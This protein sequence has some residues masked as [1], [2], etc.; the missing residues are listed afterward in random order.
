[1][2]IHIPD[3]FAPSGNTSTGTAGGT[4]FGPFNLGVDPSQQFFTMP[5]GHRINLNNFTSANLAP[6]ATSAS[7]AANEIAYFLKGI[8][9]GNQYIGQVDGL[10]QGN[11]RA[12]LAEALQNQSAASLDAN[13][14]Q[15]SFSQQLRNIT[16]PSS[17]K[18]GSGSGLGGK[19]ISISTDP[20]VLAQEQMN[21]AALAAEVNS[22]NIQANGQVE[23]ANIGAAASE[24]AT[25]AS[26]SYN[27][28]STFLNTMQN[29]G[30]GDL[31]GAAGVA[32]NDLSNEIYNMTV[33][34]H[35]VM[36]PAELTN[37]VMDYKAPN[38]VNVFD[39]AFPGLR[40][41]NLM[42]GDQRT[43][44]EYLAW[45]NTLQNLASAYNLPA[46]FTSPQYMKQLWEGNVSATELEDRVVK[47]Y[48]AY[49]NEDEATKQ[50]LAKEY[51]IT[52]AEGAAYFLNPQL[53]PQE[54][55]MKAKP[56]AG[57]SLE[58]LRTAMTSAPIQAYANTTGLNLNKQGAEQLGSMVSSGALGTSGANA[59]GQPYDFS[60]VRSAIANASHDQPLTHQANGIPVHGATVDTNQLVGAQI[61]GY[62]GGKDETGGPTM[63]QNQQA[64]QRAE[65]SRLAPFQAGGGYAEDNKGAVGVGND[66]S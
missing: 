23:A 45:K 33:T 1:M 27:A 14:P 38:G 26:E 2:S 41:H 55:K 43:P 57:M 6:N 58:Q 47:G 31:T 7:A 56:P 37:F 24:R 30:F 62:T 54:M 51:G 5:N 32:Y 53:T 16:K 66:R 64:V 49:Q 9:I 61:S 60:Q 18:S 3:P 63:V 20:T 36:K 40:E 28:Y 4:V 34:D 19:N 50:V 59:P 42:Y 39:A 10:N 29:W 46:N 17:T 12:N 48:V 35:G 11:L 15:I 52:P 25:T 21:S 22:A 8:G 65:Q 44:T 13:A